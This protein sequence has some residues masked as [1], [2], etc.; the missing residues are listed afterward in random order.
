MK[1]LYC[2]VAFTDRNGTVK[3]FR[4]MNELELN[5]STTDVF[6]FDS[7]SDTLRRSPRETPLPD[8]FW[9]N[10][11]VT[12]NIYNINVVAGMNGSGKST[13][14][15]Y[16]MD[17]LSYIYHGFGQTLSDQ[18]RIVR[19]DP[20]D[21]RNLLVFE[22][23]DKVFVLDMRHG[24]T[25]RQL[26]TECF[27]KPPLY[28]GKK[29]AQALLQGMKVINLTNTLTQ[30]DYL[31]HIGNRNER[32]RN[33][34]VYDCS[35]GA[36]VGPDVGQHFLYEVYKQ[37][38]YLFDS[39]QMKAR[40]EL[41]KTIP[42]LRLPLELRVR[43]L[44]MRYMNMVKVLTGK[45]INEETTALL[46]QSSLSAKL[47]LLCAT[48]YVENVIELTKS[49]VY[50]YPTN[51]ACPTATADNT[52]LE[53]R[54]TA[55]VNRAKKW[56][57][58]I[59]SE[60][61]VAG[62]YDGTLRV[63]DV[64]TGKILQTL[65]GHKD[66]VRCVTALPDG[67]VVSGS[68]DNTLR[69]WDTATGQCLQTLTGH[70]GRITCTAVLADGHIVSGSDDQTLR[71]WD[72]TTGECLQ[73]FK[74]NLSRVTCIA[75]LH[76]GTVVGG[77]WDRLNVWDLR[78]GKCIQSMNGHTHKLACVAILQDNRVVSGSWDRTLRVWDAATGQCLNVLEG[79]NETVT[80]V[81]E[82]PNGFIV[83]GSWDNSLRV[84]DV[85]TGK[86]CNVLEGHTGGIRS[87]SV[88]PDGCVVSGSE[89][90]T[91]RVWDI[92]S[93]QCLKSF[94]W[95]NEKIACTAAFSGKWAE[96][97]PIYNLI[98][99]RANHCNDYINYV[100]MDP[101]NLLSRFVKDN[102]NSESYTL[103]F[104][105]E[106]RSESVLKLLE[107][108]LV[109]F[110]RKYHNTCTPF[111]T[112]DFNW[113]LSS[114]E[115]NLLRIFSW[116]F[117]V[118]PRTGENG[119]YRYIIRNNPENIFDGGNR[120]DSVLLIM[121]EADLTFHP[122]W[123]R[124]LIHILTAFL[125]AIYPQDCIKDLQLIL[126]T[127]SPLLLGDIPREN[128]RFLY[129]AKE[130]ELIQGENCSETFGQ[131]IHTI[132][133]DSFFLEHGTVGQFAANKIDA[134]AKRLDALRQPELRSNVSA[135]EMETIRRTISLVAPG[136]L[137]AKLEQMLRE[138]DAYTERPN[139]KTL[140]QQTR[141]LSSE[142]RQWLLHQLQEEK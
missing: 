91:L 71:V 35:I 39:R 78:T 131:N 127:H 94:E 118:F 134:L 108:S 93:G 31:L 85:T 48:T 4:G 1:L 52:Q 33:D 77:S 54:L 123:Q 8:Q 135:K 61:V 126:T 38:K 12:T 106:L 36:T 124:R 55:F 132:L 10:G 99:S 47:A 16:L 37:V 57:R 114:G 129:R 9:A 2:Y 92:N 133:K 139:V 5:F 140:A 23:D 24:Q 34:F 79:H 44:L 3:P 107:S 104:T 64:K 56:I 82:L 43:P 117:H 17:L 120:C 137:R 130:G 20:T 27:A 11:T 89:D 63:Y 42:E 88:L 32:L 95:D 80:C 22:T 73:A 72:A 50:I 69:V 68:N 58:D 76:D 41:E 141:L 60:A 96:N 13:A 113:G 128:V 67:R 136:V 112:L 25:S 14:I 6:R 98:I 26:H 101:E 45:E 138:V 105:P 53:N 142:E 111:Y 116:L 115:E 19:H 29:K 30:R 7:T 125:P 51:L 59:H 122:E 81:V 21:N 74:V 46:Y 40:K 66:A 15:Q 70:M 87:L 75:E 65:A 86:C 62:S 110:L 100:M 121:D 102:N 28:L 84:W 109:T 49:K 119:E 97:D 18:E 90:N 103:S 83:S